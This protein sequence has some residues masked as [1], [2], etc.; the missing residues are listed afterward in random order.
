MQQQ[1]VEEVMDLQQ[2]LNPDDCDVTV[3]DD[4][5]FEELSMPGVDGNIEDV[6]DESDSG[7]DDKMEKFSQQ[8]H[9][10]RPHRDAIPD[11]QAR[12]SDRKTTVLDPVKVRKHVK[13]TLIKKQKFQH[14]QPPPPQGGNR[15]VRKQ[16]SKRKQIP[17]YFEDF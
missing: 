15:K 13:R 11:D 16:Q 6:S 3:N 14:R 5:I 10:H 4:Q 17:D 2:E 1:V 12:G 8:N 7:P 9:L